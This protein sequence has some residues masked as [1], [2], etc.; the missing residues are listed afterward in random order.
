M[1][2]LTQTLVVLPAFNEEGSVA[3][4]VREVLDKLPGVGCL[5]VD[6][7]SRDDTF[8]RATAAGATVAR[9]SFNLGVGAAMRV[10]F[11]YAM[12]NGYS[13]VVQIDADG[14]HDPGSVPDMLAQLREVDIVIAAR[15]AGVGDYEARGPRRLA[16]KVLARTLSRVTGTKLTDATSGFRASGP[17]AVAVFADNYPAE[18]LGDTIESLVIAS[19]FNLTVRQIPTVMRR[20]AAGV[21][22]HNPLR[23]ATYLGRAVMALTFALMRPK[24]SYGMEAEQ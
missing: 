3:D 6:D 2:E 8:G 16:M 11:R 14:Q 24:S 4:V 20:R 17:R 5:V 15:F 23:S 7:G 19:R 1:S 21:P 22:S 12:E 10:G 18:Y 9:L 13:K